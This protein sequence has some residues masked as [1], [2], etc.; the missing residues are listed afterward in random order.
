[1]IGHP[2][3]W[4]LM[5]ALREMMEGSGER[6]VI[7]RDADSGR[8]VQYCPAD[9]YDAPE[10]GE[11]TGAI[12]MLDLPL[13]SLDAGQSERAAAFFRARK[14]AGP[15][16]QEAVFVNGRGGSRPGFAVSY[17]LGCGEDPDEAAETGLRLMSEVHGSGPDAPLEIE[18]F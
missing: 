7:V 17:Q 15:S 13:A 12:I 18:S 5:A 6:A 3:R 1:M 4:E 2:K 8:F 14:V 16:E 11:P 9:T 10:G